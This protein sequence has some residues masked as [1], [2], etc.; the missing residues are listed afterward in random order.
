[1]VKRKLTLS[2]EKDLLDEV[3]RVAAA[4]GVSLSSLVEE[5]FES[6]VFERWAEV[7]SKEL[8]LGD[9]EPTTE[10]EI[11]SGRPKGFDAAAT[12]REFRE[13]H[14]E[15][16]HGGLRCFQLTKKPSES[17]QSILMN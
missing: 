15:K 9:L 5:Y 10:P 12:V 16:P 17:S 2:V 13:N 7:L 8:G 3:K 1:M 11:A 14:V 4:R 6:L